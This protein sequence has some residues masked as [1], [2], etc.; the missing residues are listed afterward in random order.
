MDDINMK[1]MFPMTALGLL[2]LSG[3]ALASDSEYSRERF[4]HWLSTGYLVM[5]PIQDGVR[6]L[7]E[8]DEAQF[9]YVAQVNPNFHKEREIC[10]RNSRFDYLHQNGNNIDGL[11]GKFYKT[12]TGACAIGKGA[13]GWG[14]AY[15]ADDKLSL[16]DIDVDHVVPLKEAWDS[17]ADK[18]NDNERAVFAN[19]PH[20]L[21]ITSKTLNRSKSDKGIAD[22]PPLEAY[23]YTRNNY[24]MSGFLMCDYLTAYA[25]IKINYKL[26]FSTDEIDR[27]EEVKDKCFVKS[28]LVKGVISD[29]VRENIK[30]R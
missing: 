20:V 23:S 30:I 13:S 5:D 21:R 2:F 10:L 1:K 6:I 28:V 26:S 12:D 15:K 24:P 9:N 17:G 3:T 18:W 11:T 19:D 25:E 8:E 4:P 16:D 27:I 7:Y 14:N 22:W 29:S